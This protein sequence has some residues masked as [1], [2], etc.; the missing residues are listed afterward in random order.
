[1]PVPLICYYLCRIQRTEINGFF[2]KEIKMVNNN[3][4][5]LIYLMTLFRLPTS[6]LFFLRCFPY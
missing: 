5:P 2:N 3:K 6:Q 1:M 4:F